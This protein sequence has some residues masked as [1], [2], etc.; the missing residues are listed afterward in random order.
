MSSDSKL[1]DNDP[2]KTDIKTNEEP[3]SKEEKPSEKISLPKP[4]PN[5]EIRA[6]FIMVPAVIVIIILLR[7]LPTI[8]EWFGI[9]LP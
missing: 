1:T 2:S 9:Q 3:I 6:A 5:L 8:L 4:D 7:W